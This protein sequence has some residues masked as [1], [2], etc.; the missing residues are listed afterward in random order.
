MQ[1]LLTIKLHTWLLLAGLFGLAVL[2]PFDV[3]SAGA[4]DAMAEILYFIIINFTGWLLWM[5]GVILDFGV[6]TFVINFGTNFNSNG[7]G[8]AV[9][10]LW[11]V[12]RDFFNI[13][14]I[15]GLVYIG[16]KM[17]LN[18]DDSRTKST[19]VSLIIAALL[20][21]FSL[22]I[23]KFVV[24]FS[25][26][27][28]SEVAIAGFETSP[29][30][31]LGDSSHIEIGNTFFHLMGLNNTV[32]QTPE[33]IPEGAKKPWSYIFGIGIINII[34]AF[35][36]GVG[37]IMLIIR[38]VVLSI[39]MVLS[40][41]MFLGMIFPGFQGMSSKYWS[42]FFKQA[43]YAPVYIVMIFF[44]ATI[45]NNFFGTGTGSM[46]GGGIA[47]L[48]GDTGVLGAAGGG[49]IN[50]GGGLA[51]FILSAAFLIA[52]VQVAG[53]L[54]SDGSGAMAKV[55]GFVNS[56]VQGAVRGGVRFGARNTVG[57]GA[58]GV[59]AISNKAANSR[60]YRRLNTSLG[61][62]K[63]GIGRG[64]A[65]AMDAGLAAGGR[66][67]IAGSRTAADQQTVVRTRQ[68]QVNDQSGVIDREKAIDAYRENASDVNKA[69]ATGAVA[70]LTESE[71]LNLSL[72]RPKDERIIELL[73]DAQLKT[74]AES[75]DSTKKEIADL[76][77][78][79]EALIYE[80]FEKVLNDTSS[81]ATELE[82]ALAG[83]AKAVKSQ[84]AEQ[85]TSMDAKR[86][87]TQAVAS[88]ITDKQLDGLQDSGKVPPDQLDGIKKTRSEG[89]T[90]IAKTGAI[91]GQTIPTGAD[92]KK[93]AQTQRE[94]LVKGNV[95]DV[96]KLPA[97]VFAEQEM[98][99]LITPA[100]VEQRMRN[101]LSVDERNQ[102]RNNIDGLIIDSAGKPEGK[103]VEK[104]WR[105]WVKRSN[106][107]NELGLTSISVSE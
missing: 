98:A 107:G 8:E 97:A 94:K 77:T 62:G 67:S 53:K 10:Q 1:R 5:G 23:T 27:L 80:K 24:D 102:V 73:S 55:G 21:N 92:G 103:R 93:F 51:P 56:R 14:F 71:L 96:G 68:K 65:G 74:K 32:L 75:G 95:Q 101:G 61:Q 25:N 72:N 59:G 3:A 45:L 43:F 60:A 20:I 18:S 33:G 81:T 52:A 100:M 47:G 48:A 91:K 104:M 84:T 36:F 28:A 9:N 64:V 105:E 38:F 7:V 89:L 11:V 69:K 13:L 82:A 39:Y 42:G 29:P 70:K 86:L 79:R 54:S 58:R 41:F 87:N 63:F 66:A 6:N 49:T 17:I 40:P 16:F 22:F 50:F 76:K 85:L 44:S 26:T 46:Q 57:Y 2:I 30:E 99:T 19:L 37:G 15:F 12:V 31:R 78:K 35:A 90:S 88:Q 34:G 4:S 83:L 106:Y